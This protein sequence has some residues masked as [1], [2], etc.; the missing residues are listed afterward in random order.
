[1]ERRLWARGLDRHAHLYR[2]SVVNSRLADDLC[3]CVCACLSVR[4]CVHARTHV[5]VCWHLEHSHIS[6]PLAC[7]R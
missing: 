1:M 3:V 7:S 5:D 6:N 2:E 4:V